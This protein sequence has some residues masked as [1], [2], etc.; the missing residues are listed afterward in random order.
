MSDEINHRRN[1]FSETG[2]MAIAATDQ[3]SVSRTNSCSAQFVRTHGVSDDGMKQMLKADN[4][5]YP[6]T[7]LAE[8]SA[9]VRNVRATSPDSALAAIADAK[10]G[11]SIALSGGGSTSR[12]RASRRT[13]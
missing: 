10:I 8:M 7:V 4:T 12:K 2:A 3:S 1:R 6:T 11:S 9:L 13:K 5:F